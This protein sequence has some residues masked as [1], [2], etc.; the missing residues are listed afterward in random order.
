MKDKFSVNFDQLATHL[1]PDPVIRLSDVEGRIEKVAYDMVRFR[2]NSDT[3]QLWKIQ[4]GP[5]GPVI[6]ALYGEDGSKVSESSEDAKTDWEALPEKSA[7]HIFYKGEH[8]TSLS[9]SDLGIPEEEFPVLRRWLPKKLAADK[10]LQKELF[11]KVAAPGR[12]MITERFPEFRDVIPMVATASYSEESMDD[13]GADDYNPG[14]EPVPLS[15]S[16]R[17]EQLREELSRS[18]ILE[19]AEMLLKE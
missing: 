8:L 10:G 9:S 19:L 2:D 1:T 13:C 17:A 4:E 15:L 12:K 5:E 16:E 11:S 14:F 7:M 18:Q 3:D 6:V